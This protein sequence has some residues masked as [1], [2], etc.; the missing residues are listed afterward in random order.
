[1]RIKTLTPFAVAAALAASPALATVMATDTFFDSGDSGLVD[2]GGGVYSYT[3][4]PTGFTAAGADKLV[5]GYI[6]KDTGAVA[7]P[8]V[9]SATYNGVAMDLAIQDTTGSNRVRNSIFYLDNVATDG[10]L[11][12]TF[13]D[14]VPSNQTSWVVALYALSGTADGFADTN[15]NK[16]T[17]TGAAVSVGTATGFVLN[18]WSRNNGG[19]ELVTPSDFTEDVDL[20]VATSGGALAALINSAETTGAGSYATNSTGTNGTAGMVA[21]SFDAVPEPGSL[22]LMG[23]GGLLIARRRRG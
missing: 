5:L 15:S 23:L 13:N 8:V 14:S 2:E 3:Y 20:S 1:M 11:K 19:L 7:G 4:T 9:A 6:N 17:G 21:A 22:A 10:N 12:I 18:V 16:G